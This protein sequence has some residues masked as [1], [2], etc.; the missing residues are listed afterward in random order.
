[1]PNALVG[2]DY[3]TLS[4]KIMHDQLLSLQT[5]HSVSAYVSMWP[6]QCNADAGA[7][8]WKKQALYHMPW[9]LTLA[10]QVQTPYHTSRSFA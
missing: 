8:A 5:V 1:M 9:C 10:E 6:R 2:N 3:M 4:V 7:D